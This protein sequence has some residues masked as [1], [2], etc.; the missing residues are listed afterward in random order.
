MKVEKVHATIKLSRDTGH[1][2]K[3]LELGAEGTTEPRETWQAAQ[4]YLYSE[5]SKQ[6][7]SLWANG[8][9]H[10]PQESPGDSAESTVP[11]PQPV[12]RSN[13]HPESPAHHCQEHGVAFKRYTRSNTAWWSH[14]K[15]DGKWC[16]EGK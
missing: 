9:G 16:R 11:A 4:G 10:K 3:S 5:L 2:W 1:G 8:N 6:L 12:E 14:R 7:R 13:A 15:P